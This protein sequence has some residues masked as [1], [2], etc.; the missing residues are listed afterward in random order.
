[1]SE[2]AP[3]IT[4]PPAAAWLGGLGLVPFV[5]LSIAAQVIPGDLRPAALLALLAY[6]AV[7]L[8]F[9]GGIHWGVAMTRSIAQPDQAIDASRLAISVVPSLLGWATLLIDPRLGLALLAAGFAAQ[10]LVDLRATQAG[11][12]PDWYPRLRK[13]LTMVVIAALVVAEFGV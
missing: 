2:S 1:M 9:L 3:R 6:G 11:L 13:P 10:L 5:A 7:I 12:A 4:V 8:S